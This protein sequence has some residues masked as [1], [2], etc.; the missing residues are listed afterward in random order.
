MLSKEKIESQDKIH[1]DNLQDFE[2]LMTIIRDKS[3]T[4]KQIKVCLQLVLTLLFP[5]YQINFLPSS[6]LLLNT[7]NKENQVGNQKII[8]DKHNFNLFKSLIK[9][10]FC[11]DVFFG[12]EISQKYN[13]G[14]PQAKAIVQKFKKR[15]K[16]LAQ[17]R[18]GEKYNNESFSLFAQYISILAVGERKDINLL[19]QYTIYQLMDEFKRFRLKEDSDLYIKAKMAGAQDLQEVENWMGDIHS[20][21][22]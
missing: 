11:L 22:E 5:N 15:Q 3:T 13:P 14:G 17:L 9:Q 1:L 16:K 7:I 12:E 2:I 8:I 20:D 21:K 6:L 10:I 4:S 18:K 19:L